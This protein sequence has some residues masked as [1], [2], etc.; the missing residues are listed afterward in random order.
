LSSLVSGGIARLALPLGYF[1]GCSAKP[2]SITFVIR[3][4]LEKLS[5]ATVTVEEAQAIDVV[6]PRQR[7]RASAIR[8]QRCEP[9]R[10]SM[11]PQTGLLTSHR[12]R[13]AG[14]FSSIARITKVIENGFAEHPLKV[15]KGS[16]SRAMPPETRELN[17]ETQKVA[18]KQKELRN[19]AAL[20][21]L[22]SLGQV[23]FLDG[24][25]HHVVRVDH[26]S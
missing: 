17:A 3:A 1:Q 11:S 14:Q 20:E 9:R 2:F 6:Q 16:A 8:R 22:T 19:A 23:F 26:L 15:S 5:G 10:F 13:G 12:Y 18:E 7:K 25:N 4:M 24:G 21:R